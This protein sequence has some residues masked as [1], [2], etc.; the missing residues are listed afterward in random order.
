MV[1]ACLKTDT[2]AEYCGVSKALLEKL[3]VVGGGPRF[4]KLGQG[5]GRGGRVVYRHSDLDAW[6]DAHVR[7]STSDPGGDRREPRTNSA[8]CL[9][10]L[11][12]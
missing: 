5:G 11:R 12:P 9:S 3:R 8:G 2:A 7:R 6:I 4:A 1:D 10:I